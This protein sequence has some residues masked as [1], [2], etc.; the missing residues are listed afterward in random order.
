MLSP[1]TKLTPTF[2]RA[3]SVP[4][5]QPRTLEALVGQVAVHTDKAGVHGDGRRGRRSRSLEDL[6]QGAWEGG[7]CIDHVGLSSLD[8][9]G[10]LGEL[11]DSGR[12][13]GGRRLGLDKTNRKRQSKDKWQHNHSRG[14]R[15]TQQQSKGVRQA[16]R[17]ARW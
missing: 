6:G 17:Q 14:R 7:H 4:L 13:A 2:V 16:R 5:E 15:R 9:G 10:Q 3:P 11:V 12:L 8:E 1:H